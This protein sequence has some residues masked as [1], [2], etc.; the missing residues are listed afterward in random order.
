MTSQQKGWWGCG[1]YEKRV[2]TEGTDNHW[3]KV[4][5]PRPD[6]LEYMQSR[7]EQEDGGE[8]SGAG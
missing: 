3:D 7:G 2:L 8:K 5:C 1:D 6:D 4:P